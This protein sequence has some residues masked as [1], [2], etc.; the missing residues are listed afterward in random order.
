MLGV[1]AQRTAEQE[2]GTGRSE[3]Q[4][5]RFPALLPGRQALSRRAPGGGARAPTLRRCTGRMAAVCRSRQ[6]RAG[7][8]CAMQAWLGLCALLL[9]A[10]G[11]HLG[12][13][14]GVCLWQL[15]RRRA[16]RVAT[17]PTNNARAGATAW[18]SE[19]DFLA[20]T[21]VSD[22]STGRS[23][24]A[25]FEHN[26]GSSVATQC[27]RSSYLSPYRLYARS[28]T[29]QQTTDDL[30]LVEFELATVDCLVPNPC[31][32]AA[33][34]RLVIRTGVDA[35]SSSAQE[36]GGQLG[37]QRPSRPAR[38]HNTCRRTGRASMYRRSQVQRERRGH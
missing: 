28:L 35:S 32:S 38:T 34:D 6:R 18:G 26:F 25:Y 4:A 2:S 14:R 13:L 11:E 29:P 37:W 8:P 33:L 23:L 1:D 9:A 7:A 31:C 24:S 36:Q 12:S 22:F 16:A 27:F 5:P 17:G 3:Q 30:S 10:R 20:R 19:L 15:R 21:S